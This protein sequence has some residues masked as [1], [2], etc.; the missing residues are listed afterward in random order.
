MAAVTRRTAVILLFAPLTSGVT[1]CSRPANGPEDSTSD[2][3]RRSLEAIGASY[4]SAHGVD[5]EDARQVSDGVRRAL[6]EWSVS[7][8][9]SVGLL[10]QGQGRLF[11][12]E[13]AADFEAARTVVIGGWVLSRTEAAASLTACLQEF[14]PGHGRQRLR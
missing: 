6:R 12:S 8:A 1:V 4:L 2:R 9:W 14:G 3:W 11:Q 7:H 10:S 13:V 5:L